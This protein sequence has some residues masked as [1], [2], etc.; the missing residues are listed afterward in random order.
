VIGR[1]PL[2]E[3][4]A[5]FALRLEREAAEVRADERLRSRRATSARRV[6][7]GAIAGF[8]LA[9]GLL[10]LLVLDKLEVSWFAQLLGFPPF[11]VLCGQAILLIGVVMGIGV[12][13]DSD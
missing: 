6:L 1:P 12:A 7:A 13:I 10:L 8:G 3:S 11:T 4:E 5:E 9:A 2:A